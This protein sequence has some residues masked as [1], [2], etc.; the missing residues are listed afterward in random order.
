MAV[1]IKMKSRQALVAGG[2]GM[3][4]FWL[5]LMLGGLLLTAWLVLRDAR[6]HASGVSGPAVVAPLDR[7]SDARRAQEASDRVKERRVDDAAKE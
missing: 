6:D 4:T 5:V 2:F 3:K 7:A 1:R